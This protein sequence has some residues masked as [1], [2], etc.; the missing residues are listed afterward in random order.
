MGETPWVV[1]TNNSSNKHS[2][3]VGVILKSAEG[4]VIECVVRL[5]FR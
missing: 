1:S 5:D 3:G 4:N 2:G